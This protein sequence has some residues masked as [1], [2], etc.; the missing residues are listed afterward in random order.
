MQSPVAEQGH[1]P[2]LDDLDDPALY[3]NR[4]LSWLEFNQRV[5]AEAHDPR[6]RLLDRVK[7][8]AITASNLDEFYAKR[9]G[10]LKRMLRTDP[11]TVTVDGLTIGDQLANVIERCYAMCREMDGCWARELA[12]ALAER[13]IR[14]VRFEQLQPAARERLTGYFEHAIFPVLTPLVVDPAH[15]FPFISG[16]SLSLA[17]NVRHPES[18]QER[19]ARIKVPQNRPRFVDA[20]DLRFVPLED[21]IAAH[22]HLLFP[23]MDVTEWRCLRVLRSAE[24]G[25]P[26]EES[27][28]LLELI[29]SELRRRR[30]AEAVA[31]AVTGTLAPSRLQLLLEELEL[32]PGDVY[33]SQ[34][35]L[36]LA[37]L[38]Q[39]AALPIPELADPP[40]TPAIPTALQQRTD[41]AS[42]FNLIR[43]RDVLVHHP[44]E[45]FDASVVRFID[46]AAADASVLAIKQTMYRTSPDSPILASLIDAAG[47][48]KQVA[49]LVELTARFDEA[50]N[51]EWARKLEDAG[52]HV[53]YGRPNLKIHSK[54]CLV[55]REEPAGVT[56]YA[57]IGTGNY[58]SRTARLYTDLGLF[59][60]DAAICA[61]LV[62]IFNYLTGYADRLESHELLVAPTTLRYE[63]ERRVRRE[64]EAAQAGRP[65]RVVFKVNA[66]EDRE[67]TRL[68]YEASAAGVTV[69]LI[70]RG[71]CRLRPGLPGVS[72][73]VRVVS[74][75][76]R[77]LEHSRVYAFA[78]D[79]AGEYFIGSADLMKRNLDERIEVLVPVR[80][81]DLQGQLHDL[82]ELLLADERQGW[83]L[84]D[85]IW[86]RDPNAAGPGSH[87]ALLGAAPFS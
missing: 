37:D 48:G 19:F 84:R 75:I 66:L 82:L 26:G 27:D 54:I 10:W 28:D 42:F 73:N 8:L 12:P 23:G 36:G 71:I 50:N 83:S 44:F 52:V 2:P 72:E 81:A 33:Q 51:I 22:V 74:V 24:I 1:R 56:M 86:T 41:A 14:L 61:D 87:A 29:E 40:F 16:G 6:N 3:L 79:G 45:S 43:E 59:T 58:N 7:F 63:L 11:L 32:G 65:A 62:R 17:L 69:D 30:L 20:G 34:G 31:L 18:G 68:L 64:I 15:P 55:V 5:L 77:F 38:M 53:A 13:G 25:S 78:N 39:I 57:H 47:R 49:V 9:V 67:F 76:G 70:V 4:E 46:E 85:Q 35:L 21:L 80:R 60:A